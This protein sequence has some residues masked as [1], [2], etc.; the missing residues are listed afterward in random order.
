M[1]D[2]QGPDSRCPA[3]VT[4]DF[5]DGKWRPMIIYWL[6]REPLRFTGASVRYGLLPAIEQRVLGAVVLEPRRTA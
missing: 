4:L 3:E 1:T 6:L 5:L 2:P